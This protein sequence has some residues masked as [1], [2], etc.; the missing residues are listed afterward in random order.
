MNF[1]QLVKES[2]ENAKKELG[3]NDH[4]RYRYAALELRMSLE[5]I[6]YDRLKLYSEELPGDEL[7]AWQ[8]KKLLMAMLEVD[9]FADQAATISIGKEESQEKTGKLQLLG[10]DRCLTLAEIKKFYDRLGS[11]LHTPTIDQIRTEKA[12]N[13]EKIKTRCEELISILEEV[14]SSRIYNAR[15]KTTTKISCE[16]CGNTIVR[17]LLP[18]GNELV[19]NCSNCG[20]KYKLQGEGK[21][22]VRWI[23]IIEEI[24]CANSNC[25]SAKKLFEVEL[26]PG[27]NWICSSCKGRNTIQLGL[28]HE[29]CT[30]DEV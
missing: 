16:K 8:P 7:K 2:V 9:P 13:F 15:F 20:A 26:K 6:I 21:E 17:S 4:T 28:V 19:A 29:P 22:K 23:P 18:N 12:V 1:R 25:Q 27:T 14:L 10:T 3:S 5:A 30:S 11:Y 24:K